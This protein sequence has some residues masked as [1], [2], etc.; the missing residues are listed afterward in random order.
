MVPVIIVK[1][2][3]DSFQLAMNLVAQECN[4]CD[5]NKTLPSQNLLRERQ[6][7]HTENKNSFQTNNN[8]VRAK[9]NR[10]E[11]QID[12]QIMLKIAI[13]ILNYMQNQK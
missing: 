8:T 10:L 4:H 7:A 6:S 1:E 11:L 12:E 3:R 9:R 5:G 2:E 13:T